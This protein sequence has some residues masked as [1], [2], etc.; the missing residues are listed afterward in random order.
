MRASC[1]VLAV[2]S[3]NLDYRTLAPAGQPAA[4]SVSPAAAAT[5]ARRPR[6]S[7]FCGAG[8]QAALEDAWCAR[9]DALVG[10][11]VTRDA[12]ADGEVTLERSHELEIAFGRRLTLPRVVH[13]AVWFDFAQLCGKYHP[14]T[15]SYVNEQ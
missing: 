11:E 1:H 2:G 15:N 6:G 8:A 7:Y 13:G 10:S 14:T 12:T 5:V 9:R 4:A 3:E